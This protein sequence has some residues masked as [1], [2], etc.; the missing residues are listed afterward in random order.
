MFQVKSW[1]VTLM[2][3]AIAVSLIAVGLTMKSIPA[4]AAETPAA[5]TPVGSTATGGSGTGGSGTFVKDLPNEVPDTAPP[6]IVR[7]DSDFLTLATR[8]GGTMFWVLVVMGGLGIVIT[9]ERMVTLGRGQVDVGRFMGEVNKGLHAKGVQGGL[10]VCGRNKGPVSTLVQYGLA[11]ATRGAE[12]VEKAVSTSVMSQLVNARRGL[13]VLGFLAQSAPLIGFVSTFMGILNAFNAAIDS[14]KVMAAQAIGG[15]SEAVVPTVAGLA[16]AIVA[17]VCINLV[18]SRID[19]LQV[20]LEE[21][22]DE[23]V[24]ALHSVQGLKGRTA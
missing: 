2:T 12:G 6:P 18:S 3:A 8:A 14:N 21:A 4:G 1:K 16:V 9:V 5:A 20:Q 24:D 10:E 15:L 17:N 13:G 11:R 7:P 19:K 22:G 23:L